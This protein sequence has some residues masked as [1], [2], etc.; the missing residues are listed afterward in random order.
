MATIQSEQSPQMGLGVEVTPELLR[1]RR[2]Q[3]RIIFDRFIRNKVA[4]AGFVALVLITLAAIFAPVITHQTAT[5]DPNTATDVYHIASG[6]YPGHPLGTDYVGRDELARLLFGARVSLLVGLVAMLVSVLIG[7]SIGALAGYY[8]GWLDNAMMRVTDA[9]LA[10]PLYLILFV[11]AATFATGSG[12][13]SVIGII[14]LIAAFSWPPTARIVRGEFLGLKE[15][16]FLLAART[17]GAND[18]RLML[19]HILP[20]A[21]GP[22]I[23]A[24]TL[25]VGN[26]IITESTLSFFSFGIQ[27]PESSWGTMLASSQDYFAGQPLM[28]LIPGFA[29]LITVL[30]I[31]LMG[32]G[33]RD[34]LDPYMTER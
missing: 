19:R 20:N 17:L 24:A 2:G 8:G 15:R 16:E 10:I 9:F 34:A 4:V 7:V 12:S 22:I 21:A 13:A 6:P 18:F 1:K 5:Y 25:L 14:I 30:S 28:V 29:I 11:L 33:L 26:T 23:V 32:D 27:P 31:N 3:L